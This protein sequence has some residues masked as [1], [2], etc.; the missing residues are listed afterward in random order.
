M[1]PDISG[2]RRSVIGP[3][4][5]FTV[6]WKGTRTIEA[7]A[8]EAGR[9]LSAA[10]PLGTHG[11]DDLTALPDGTI[12]GVWVRPEENP[13]S[14][15]GAIAVATSRD[16]LHFTR[17]HVISATFEQYGACREPKLLIAGVHSVIAEW[18]C[19]IERD[20]SR[21]RQEVVEVARY[22]R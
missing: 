4:G 5:R 14:R 20:H 10:H 6:V 3:T 16:G 21:R 22:S 12:V 2:A 19:N 1:P 15:T 11:F 18:I 7:T 8:G 9:A 13:L 17:R